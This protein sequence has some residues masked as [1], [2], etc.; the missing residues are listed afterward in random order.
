GAHGTGTRARPLEDGPGHVDDVGAVHLV[1]PEDGRPDRG[2][3]EVAV[4][5]DRLGIVPDVRAE[6]ET[7]GGSG[8]AAAPTVREGPLQ[9]GRVLSPGEHV[10]GAGGSLEEVRHVQV[11]A[12]VEGHLAR[13][14]RLLGLALLRASLLLPLLRLLTTLPRLGGGG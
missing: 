9:P 11:V 4:G 1:G 3:D 5:G 6:V 2:L 12:V 7:G 10:S 8:A 13:R 14:G